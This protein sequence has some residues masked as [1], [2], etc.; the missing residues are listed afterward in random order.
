MRVGPGG[1]WEG[2]ATLTRDNNTYTRRASK[3][4][5]ILR[6]VWSTKKAQ[7]AENAEYGLLCLQDGNVPACSGTAV[8]HHL[9]LAFHFADLYASLNM[10]LSISDSCVQPDRPPTHTPSLPKHRHHL[11]QTNQSGTTFFNEAD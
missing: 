4:N 8:Q 7:N 9:I 10:T 5:E 11:R 1:A 2:N 3:K 6:R